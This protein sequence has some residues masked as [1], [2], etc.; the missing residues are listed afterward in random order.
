M[1]KQN[2][3]KQGW[4]QLYNTSQYIHTLLYNILKLEVWFA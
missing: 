2:P 3:L 4:M 1:Q